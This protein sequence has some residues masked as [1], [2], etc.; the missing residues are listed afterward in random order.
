[1]LNLKELESAVEKTE[2]GADGEPPAQKPVQEDAWFPLAQDA[3]SIMAEDLPE[4]VQI[5]EGIVAER[6]KLVIGSGSKSFKTWLTM[7]MALSISHG[8]PFLGR[9][10]ERRR[11]LYLNL[12][13]KPLT[14]KR[15]LQ[16]I[17]G[18]KGITVEPEWFLHLPLRGRMAGVSVDGFVGRIIRFVQHF[19]AGVVVADP[20][21]KMNVEGDENSSH[22]Q[23]V[24]F[25]HLDR[26][27]TEGEATLIL[28]DHFSKG[29]Q[30]E[31]DPLDAIRGS[32]AK[33]GDLDAAMVLRKHE[34]DGCFRVDLVH[35][36]LPPVD[37]FCI[38]WD[39]PLMKVRTDLDPLAMKKAKGGRHKSHDPKK[40]LAVIRDTS[41]EDPI[42]FSAW[43]KD[44][45]VPRGTLAE[46]AATM[47]TQGWIQTVGDGSSARQ[48]ITAKG[49]SILPPAG[50][51]AP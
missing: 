45:G 1:M 27:T 3:S 33:G 32:S 9:K 49:L 16:A 22:D 51:G 13:L 8:V 42:S 5:V 36:E 14:F 25:N 31:K 23:T 26:I 6:S 11:V 2:G 48:H 43:A 20:V 24:F 39:Y 29:N 38:G 46:Y 40:L 30:S 41:P 19:K 37:P 18:A 4:L 10:T 50:N 35:R 34:V 21:Y 47:H 7:D 28:N 17:A 44:A 12:E 15:R